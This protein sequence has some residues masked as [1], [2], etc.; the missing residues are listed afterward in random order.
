MEPVSDPRSGLARWVGL[1]RGESY[2]SYWVGSGSVAFSHET[3]LTAAHNFYDNNGY[4][5]SADF[6][7]LPNYHSNDFPYSIPS[8]ASTITYHSV[9]TGS[10]GYSSLVRRYG[11][12]SIEAFSSDIAIFGA[13]SNLI[14]TNNPLPDVSYNGITDLKSSRLKQIV[15]YAPGMYPWA[16]E[17]FPSSQP[18]FKIHDSPRDGEIFYS[19]DEDYPESMVAEEFSETTA[20]VVT[21]GTSGSPMFV[22]R[23]GVWELSAVVNAGVEDLIF[24]T[25]DDIDYTAG[26]V[27]VRAMATDILEAFFSGQA[28]IGVEDYGDVGSDL[29]IGEVRIQMGSAVQDVAGN[30]LSVWLSSA[31]SSSFSQSRRLSDNE[32]RIEGAEIVLDGIDSTG[33][34]TVWI[35]GTIDGVSVRSDGDSFTIESPEMWQYTLESD[36]YVVRIFDDGDSAWFN[37]KTES[38]SRYDL[39]PDSTYGVVDAALAGQKLFF[40]PEP[41]YYSQTLRVLENGKDEAPRDVRLS[42][43]IRSLELKDEVIVAYD[44]DGDRLIA[45]NVET[46][47][48]VL[49]EMERV[50][51]FKEY[52]S[53]LDGF[54]YTSSGTGHSYAFSIGSDLAIVDHGLINSTESAYKSY[55]DS[56]NLETS[57][58]YVGFENGFYLYLYTYR[59]DPAISLYNKSG[60]LVDELEVDLSYGEQVRMMYDEAEGMVKIYR[61]S[62]ST[63]GYDTYTL[64][65]SLFA[66]VVPQAHLPFSMSGESSNSQELVLADEGILYYNSSLDEVRWVNESLEVTS[67]VES[68][69]MPLVISGE[70]DEPDQ[71]LYTIWDSHDETEDYFQMY[72]ADI[73]IDGRNVSLTNEV[74]VGGLLTESEVS[75]GFIGKAGDTLLF[76]NNVYF[77]NLDLMRLDIGKDSSPLSIEST[78]TSR[79]SSVSSEEL[80]IAGDDL[81]FVDRYSFTLEVSTVVANFEDTEAATTESVFD[82]ISW[83]STDGTVLFSTPSSQYIGLDGVYY[84]KFS[85]VNVETGDVSVFSIY[86]FDPDFADSDN[87]SIIDV[88]ELAE[89]DLEIVFTLGSLSSSGGVYSTIFDVSEAKFSE[90]EEY[91]WLA[92]DSV[93]L[94]NASDSRLLEIYDRVDRSEEPFSLKTMHLN[95]LTTNMSGDDISFHGNYMDGPFEAITEDTDMGIVTH[96]YYPWIYSTDYGWI[97]FASVDFDFSGFAADDAWLYF[98][99]LGYVYSSENTFPYVYL[100]SRGAWVYLYC[101]DAGNC[102]LYDFASDSWSAFEPTRGE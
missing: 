81:Y 91:V 39:T 54:V 86:D 13:N 100:Q 30:S 63:K 44:A 32:Y 8:N 16:P 41:N 33:N 5:E 23:N 83:D 87:T 17:G 15:G 98:P 79:L 50:S 4:Y 57:T 51:S 70:G 75:Y 95:L 93:A 43:T 47:T 78:D 45:Y 94:S 82:P 19:L 92:E 62:W 42:E 35:E 56:Q 9:L 26:W 10:R 34:Y 53:I 28:V 27:G 2:Y 12:D 66:Y 85:L 36:T 21:S 72:L 49:L 38:V 97:F 55:S 60:V 88:N 99:S 48:E 74:V 37:K 29:P 102:W 1:I 6:H 77:N 59:S 90:H 71:L 89:G 52:S 3:G 73:E 22:E 58:S 25:I 20:F 68:E 76:A 40:I 24:Q 7:F 96:A 65:P 67:I 31:N 80:A 14:G 69:S 61:P 101:D 18:T 84:G 11:G 64:D 46:D